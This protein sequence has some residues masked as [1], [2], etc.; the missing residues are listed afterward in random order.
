[1]GE[2]IYL[3]KSCSGKLMEAGLAE[4]PFAMNRVILRGQVHPSL[5]M[6]WPVGGL[7]SPISVRLQERVFF[8]LNS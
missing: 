2:Q 8:T 5:E 3:G 6:T 7:E 1:M 4:T